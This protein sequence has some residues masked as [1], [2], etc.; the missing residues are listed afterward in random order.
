MK[1]NC[2]QLELLGKLLG[3]CNR[4]GNTIPKGWRIT[5]CRELEKVIEKKWAKAIEEKRESETFK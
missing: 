4:S 3:K 1:K 2:Q 5:E